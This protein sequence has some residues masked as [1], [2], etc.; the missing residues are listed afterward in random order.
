MLL[1]SLFAFS[2]LHPLI[3]SFFPPL[4]WNNPCQDF[5]IF[6]FDKA[7]RHF[8]VLISSKPE[9]VDTL[10]PPACW[11]SSASGIWK[12]HSLSLPWQAEIIEEGN[13]HI[14]TN[15]VFSLVFWT[16]LLNLNRGFDV[17]F[18]VWLSSQSFIWAKW[19]RR[20]F[21]AGM[22]SHSNKK[23]VFQAKME[24]LL[25][26]SLIRYTYK[27]QLPSTKRKQVGH[28]PLCVLLACFSVCDR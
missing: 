24:F 2:T 27:L 8:S 25:V 9:G 3:K 16:C 5:N 14:A 22:K 11:P 10:A 1:L 6:C 18:F 23:N 19:F 13:L 20:T 7:C 12:S 26:R 15:S 28:S 17:D 21:R 4:C